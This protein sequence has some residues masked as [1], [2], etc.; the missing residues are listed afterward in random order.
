MSTGAL[1]RGYLRTE[2]V[3]DMCAAPGGFIDQTMAMCPSINLVRA[4]TLPV[5]EVS[6][7]IRL[8]NIGVDV[9]FRDI[10]MRAGDIGITEQDIPDNFPD[11]DKFILGRVF[12]SDEKYD[13]VFCDGQVSRTHQRSEWRERGEANRLQMT[14]LILG[15]EHLSTG[16]TMVILM[17]TLDTWR[18]F[19]LIHQLCKIA[20]I[21]LYKHHRYQPYQIVFLH[22]SQSGHFVHCGNISFSASKANFAEFLIANFFGDCIIFWP[23][24]KDNHAH[25][26]WCHLQFGDRARATFVRS[27][28]DKRVLCGRELKTGPVQ[29]MNGR[30]AAATASAAGPAASA[31]PEPADRPDGKVSSSPQMPSTPVPPLPPKRVVTKADDSHIEL[32]E[33]KDYPESWCLDPED[34]KASV[35]AYIKQI[36]HVGD[37]SVEAGFPYRT[38]AKP[39]VDY[40]NDNKDTRTIV[41]END[42]WDQERPSLDTPHRF[43]RGLAIWKNMGGG[44]LAPGQMIYHDPSARSLLSESTEFVQQSDVPPGEASATHQDHIESY[45]TP[46]IPSQGWGDYLRFQAWQSHGRPI[47]KDMVVQKE[48]ET[49]TPKTV[50]T[51]TSRG[52][53]PITVDTSSTAFSTGRNPKTIYQ[54]VNRPRGTYT[55]NKQPDEAGQTLDKW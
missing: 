25:N 9:E 41:N 6:H 16:G 8:K 19:K 34:P 35:R 39:P 51:V 12:K 20:D 14:E 32:P 29:R 4:M 50:T 55:N 45:T 31:L 17:H 48:Y 54:R 46:A 21:C 3:L 5:E 18:S 10:T 1:T 42:K 24:Q 38:T 40:S 49:E 36:A 22:R 27:S 33:L 43:A 23:V 47:K 11:R 30:S 52:V 15:L 44:D 37:A 13:L 26:G 53:D 7:D 28:L 2:R